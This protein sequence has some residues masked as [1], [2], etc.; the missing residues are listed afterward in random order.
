MFVFFIEICNNMVREPFFCRHILVIFLS[1]NGFI[2]W[3]GVYLRNLNYFVI[4]IYYILDSEPEVWQ[5][6]DYI[7]GIF[8]LQSDYINLTIIIQN[9]HIKINLNEAKLRN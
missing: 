8:W 1:Q 5:I 6:V 4:G 9:Y 2:N 3:N 7:L